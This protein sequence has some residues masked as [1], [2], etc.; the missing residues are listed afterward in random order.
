MSQYINVIDTIEVTKKGTG[1]WGD[2]FRPDIETEYA[3]RVIF[4]TE[5]TFIIELFEVVEE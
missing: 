1:E 3:W 5:I 4:E 2:A